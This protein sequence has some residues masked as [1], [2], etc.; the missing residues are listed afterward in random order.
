[1]GCCRRRD[2]DV[3]GRRDRDRDFKIE[4]KFDRDDFCR[5]VRRCI[6]DDLVAG[7]REDRD[8]D[9]RRHKKCWDWI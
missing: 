3:A 4:A 6:A 5:A 2:D 1:M 8:R 9:R 7:E